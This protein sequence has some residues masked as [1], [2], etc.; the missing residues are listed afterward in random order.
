MQPL[1]ASN[2]EPERLKVFLAL[3]ENTINKQI[4]NLENPEL[5]PVEKINQ[6]LL[7]VRNPMLSTEELFD[8]F[9]EISVLFFDNKTSIYF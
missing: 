6:M 3:K 2:I 7:K 8:I 4:L 9:N 5:L 1:T